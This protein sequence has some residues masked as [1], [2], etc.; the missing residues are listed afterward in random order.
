[1]MKFI[2]ESAREA[3]L[4][5]DRRLPSNEYHVGVRGSEQHRGYGRPTPFVK[6]AG[7]K[8]Q[9][10]RQYAGLYPS[11]FGT[12]Y[13]PFLGGGAVFFDLYS[14]GRIKRATLSDR[15]ENLMN[16]WATIKT[17]LRRFISE[18]EKLQK[19]VNDKSDYYQHRKEF[20]SASLSHSFLTRPDFR[21][22]ALLVYLNKTCYNGLYRVNAQGK[23]NVPFGKYRG[24]RLFDRSN[25]MSVHRALNDEGKVELRCEDFESCVEDA[26]R[27]DFIYFDPPYQPLSTT[28]SFTGYT[29]GGFGIEEQKR[30]SRVFKRLDALGCHVMLSNSHSE[31][32][33]RPLYRRYFRNKIV[34]KAPR[35][36]SCVGSKR[37]AIQEL[38]IVNYQPPIVRGRRLAEQT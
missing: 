9:L 18:L 33:L 1:M 36:I 29:V 11:S 2:G 22:A 19:D 25:L 26:K 27:G 5:R 4:N 3:E 38:V 21:K 17:D 37:G 34:V 10:L 20:N 15:N 28:S 16:L 32:V 31:E 30:L 7:G 12:Y 13:E 8:T 35:S 23:F 6:W 24:P 14:K